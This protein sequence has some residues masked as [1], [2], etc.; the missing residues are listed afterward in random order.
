MPPEIIYAAKA[1]DIWPEFKQYFGIETRPIGERRIQK[2]IWGD[3][4][5][6]YYLPDKEKNRFARHMLAL[7]LIGVSRNLRDYWKAVMATDS[8]TI[9]SPFADV[10]E[11]VDVKRYGT[12]T[13]I[14]YLFG[15][16][17]SLPQQD[18]LDMYFQERSRIERDLIKLYKE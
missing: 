18:I 15:L 5:E 7:T 9:V 17:T 11:M 2:P 8:E 12:P 16:E 1:F 4:E 10:Q 6:Q 14:G 3:Y 13:P